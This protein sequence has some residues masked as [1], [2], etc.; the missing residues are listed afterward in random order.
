MQQLFDVNY[1]HLGI[2]FT[3]PYVITDT[4]Q[5]TY[6][7]QPLISCERVIMGSSIWLP[8][9]LDHPALGGGVRHPKRDGSYA[10]KSMVCH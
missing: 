4:P 8:Q 1:F 7:R 2:A 10:Q 3:I 6:I 5:Y 9:R